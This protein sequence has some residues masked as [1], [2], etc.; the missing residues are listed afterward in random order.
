MI[1]E[2][3]R[4]IIRELDPADIEAFHD[5]Q[6]NPRVMR[7]VG[8]KA[9][10]LEENQTD[11]KE[12]ID[13]YSKPDNDFWVWAVIRKTDHEFLGTCALI[14]N[15]EQENEIGFRF[16]EKYWGNGYGQEVTV[17][18]LRYGLQ[19][20]A[21]VSIVAYVDKENTAS[22]KILERNMDFVK[23]F[24]NDAENCVDRKYVLHAVSINQTDQ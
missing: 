8:G 18:L 6:G 9:M 24:F 12:V 13:A 23:E 5:M 19:A 11:L 22:V 2:T 14:V 3:E 7:H 20:L 15:D 21:K 17:A 10:S 16:R 1:F 4:L